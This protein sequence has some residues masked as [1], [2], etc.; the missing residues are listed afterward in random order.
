MLLILWEKAI[1]IF[2]K[3]VNKNTNENRLLSDEDYQSYLD[4][5]NQLAEAYPQLVSG[6]DAQ[7]NAILNLGMNA[8]EAAKS[9]RELYNNQ[10]LLANVEINEQLKD[11]YDGV[12]AKIESLNKESSD[13]RYDITKVLDPQIKD[14]EDGKKD[15]F[16]YPSSKNKAG[17]TSYA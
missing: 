8:S 7:G 15:I 11:V 17:V 9:I 10:Q 12:L 14:L 16:T 3:G 2:Y 13:L 5:S 6:T 1:Q 4:I